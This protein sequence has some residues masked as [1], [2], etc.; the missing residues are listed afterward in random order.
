MM[1]LGQLN[2]AVALPLELPAPL[3]DAVKASPL[4][5]LLAAAGVS[6][7]GPSQGAAAEGA[8]G[9]VTLEGP[10][11]ALLRRGAYLY[12]QPTNEQ[13]ISVASSWLR[14]GLEAAASLTGG[15]RR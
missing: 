2:A 8:G 9:G 14:M 5:P 6:L 15:G 1:A 11:A 7:G 3:T 4:G 10:L 12:R 13:R